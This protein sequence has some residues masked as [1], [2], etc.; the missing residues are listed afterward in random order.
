MRSGFLAVPLIAAIAAQSAIAP[1]LAHDYEV[2]GLGISY[3]WARATAPRAPTG[4][5]FMTIENIGDTADRLIGASSP[6]AEH[7]DIH[8]TV[9]DDG[10]M[11]MRPVDAIEV[12]IAGSAELAPGGYHI[13]LIGLTEPLKKG[14]R[15]PVTL[16]FEN[17]GTVDVE[18]TVESAGAA[19]PATAAAH[20]GHD[21]PKAMKDGGHNH[22]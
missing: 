21:A 19:A 16:E 9:N 3:P 1:A 12:P 6:I 8:N 2:S 4:G 5:V 18:V 10:V 7:T 11:R 17:A 20:D 14:S 22:N 13:M 15:I